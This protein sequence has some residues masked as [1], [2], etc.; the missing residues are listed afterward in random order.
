MAV[1]FPIPVLAPV[2][3]TVFP[4]KDVVDRQTPP[5]QYRLKPS[6]PIPVIYKKVM[7]QQTFWQ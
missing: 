7:G 1:S 6:K 4:T 5:L 2:I 3:I